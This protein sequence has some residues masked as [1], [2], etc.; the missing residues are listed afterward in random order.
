MNQT[1]HWVFAVSLVASLPLLDYEFDAL[2]LLLKNL[3]EKLKVAFIAV[4]LLFMTETPARILLLA[5]RVG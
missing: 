4:K 3:E 1:V 2:L 5:E